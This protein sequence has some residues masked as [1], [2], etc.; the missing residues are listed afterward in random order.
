MGIDTHSI[1]NNLHDRGG[2]LEIKYDIEVDNVAVS[3]NSFKINIYS[4]Q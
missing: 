1:K 4:A 2:N 3:R